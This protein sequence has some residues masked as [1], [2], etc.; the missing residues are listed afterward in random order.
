MILYDHEAKGLENALT[1]IQHHHAHVICSTMHIHL[2]ERECLEAI[3]VKG[4]GV[5]IRRL[6]DA[7]AAK[8]GVKLSRTTVVTV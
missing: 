4:D 3:A 1:S 8:K 6:S 7:L 5:E 2:S